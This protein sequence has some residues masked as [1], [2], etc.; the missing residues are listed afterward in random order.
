MHRWDDLMEPG[1]LLFINGAF[2]PSK[3]IR[4][5]LK[6]SYTH[7]MIAIDEENIC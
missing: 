6:S 5:F 7:V 3:L 4:F 1:N 2:Y